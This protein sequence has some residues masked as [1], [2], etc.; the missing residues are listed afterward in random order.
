MDELA[1]D[2]PLKD[3]NSCCVFVVYMKQRTNIQIEHKTL[4][5]LKKQRIT[6]RETYDEI[7]NR[8]LNSQ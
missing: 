6:K 7:I 4:E 8:L 5:K 3:I 2:I 1:L